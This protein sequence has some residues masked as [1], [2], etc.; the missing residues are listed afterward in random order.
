MATETQQLPAEVEI[1]RQIDENQAAFE[2]KAAGITKERNV[3][4]NELYEKRAQYIK[5]H[6]PKNFWATVIRAHK[7]IAEELLGPYDSEILDHLEDL[8]IKWTD[9]GV[10]VT[11]TFSQNDFFTDRTL[12]AEH[13][14]DDDVIEC[15]GVNWKA[16]KGPDAE[17]AKESGDGKRARDE[18]GPS[19]FEFFMDIGPHPEEDEEALEMDEE[20]LDEEIEEWEEEMEDK[21]EVLRCLVEEVWADPAGVL[22]A[23]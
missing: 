14:P 7:D 12:T 19:L 8:D 15:S 5:Q 22:A 16:G 9:V 3:K 13:I 11:M 6:G 1:Q 4:R 21:K 23:Q 18:A 17:P 2:E 20:E 10:K